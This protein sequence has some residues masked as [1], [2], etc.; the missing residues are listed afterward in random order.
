M[1]DPLAWKTVPFV[2]LAHATCRLTALTPRKFARSGVFAICH[3]PRSGP[4]KTRNPAQ[5]LRLKRGLLAIG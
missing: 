4:A 2:P 3:S 1:T 5:A